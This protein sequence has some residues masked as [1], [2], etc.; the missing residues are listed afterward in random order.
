M[1]SGRPKGLDLWTDRRSILS[2]RPSTLET[3]FCGLDSRT[4]TTVRGLTYGGHPRTTRTDRSSPYG[5]WVAT[6][7]GAAPLSAS[8]INIC[9]RGSG[10][11]C[12][13]MLRNP[14]S[15]VQALASGAT[16]YARVTRPSTRSH[17]FPFEFPFNTPMFSSSFLHSKMFSY[18]IP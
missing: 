9:S 10:V 16:Q 1:G 2:V 4:S 3:K 7:W 5:L 18:G 14:I 11:P 6:G 17:F 12:Q 8:H 13:P 15:F